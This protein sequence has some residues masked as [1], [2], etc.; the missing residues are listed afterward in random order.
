[1]LVT[2]LEPYDN[3]DPIIRYEIIFR[4]AKDGLYYPV[5]ECISE[6]P[7]L[8]TS[9]SIPITV[10]TDVSVFNLAYNDLIKV[11]ARAA[12]TNDWGDFSESNTD[13]ARI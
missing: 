3:S 8:V 4:S 2:W 9:C 12:N 13:G 7:S 6:E 1:M 10:F 11:K 5:D